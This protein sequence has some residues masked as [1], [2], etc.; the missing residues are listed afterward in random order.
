MDI[1][2]ISKVLFETATEGLLV[3]DSKGIIQTINPRMIELFGYEKNELIGKT[4][5]QLVPTN[6][7]TAHTQH[8]KGYHKSPSK[9]TMGQGLNLLG[10]RKNGS[11][12]PIEI[13]LNY[14]AVD[15]QTMV[16]ALISD[17]ST[18]VE[19]L[20]QLQKEKETE[21]MY[22]DIAGTMFMLLDKQLHIKLINQKGARIIGLPADDILHQSWINSFVSTTDKSNFKTFLKPFFSQKQKGHLQHVLITNNQEERIISWHFV[23]VTNDEGI[24]TGVLGSGEDVTHQKQVENKLAKLNADLENRVKERTNALEK[25]QMLYRMIA[26]NFPNGVINVLDNDL[27]YVFVE[28]Q[29][30]YKMGITS[31]KLMGTNYLARLAP[32]YQEQIK[33]HLLEALKGIDTSFELKTNTSVYRINAVGLKDIDDTV[34][35]VLVVEQNIT[36]QK[37]AEIEMMNALDKEREL[38]ELKSRFV[39][40]AS[41]EFRTP[42]T[43]VLSSANLIAKYAQNSPFETNQIKQINR[44]KNSVRQLTNLLEDFLSLEKLEAGKIQVQTVPL[45]LVEFLDDLVDEMNHLTKVDQ[46]IISNYKGQKMAQTDKQLLKNILNNLISNA[47]K[48][49]NSGSTITLNCSVSPTQINIAVY[50]QGIGIPLEEQKQLFERFFRAKNVTNIQGTGLGLS[51]V[52]RYI[53]LLQGSIT[54]KSIET[55]GSVFSIS[56]PNHFTA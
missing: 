5:E 37:K 31:E 11:T 39:S 50:D 56:L 46:I 14:F 34:N 24:V 45:N 53:Q 6:L 17:I 2:E 32:K 28:G 26:R 52:N 42:L 48:Y 9:R 29:E 51:I 44:I 25:S 20:K 33:S 54:F 27:N 30:M 21:Q 40:M 13:S 23:S 10:Q 4:V 36:K 22:L 35:Q 3:T 12:F 19:I 7:R 16:M 1:H 47:I 43:T 41:H 38:N 8:R 15:G 49:S 55:K 18:R